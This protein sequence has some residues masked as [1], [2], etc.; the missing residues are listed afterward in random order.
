MRW[1]LTARADTTLYRARKFLVRH[2]VSASASALVLVLVTGMTAFYTAR[3]RSERD[4]AQAAADQAA[5]VS[6]FLTRLF[7]SADPR[8]SRDAELT[9]HELLDLGVAQVET[10]LS[11]QPEIQAQLLRVLG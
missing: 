8:E 3:I 10:E 2:P 9:A 5:Q 6:Q 11:G 1:A 7:K 4:R